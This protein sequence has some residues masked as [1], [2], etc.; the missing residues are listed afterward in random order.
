MGMNRETLEKLNA[1]LGSKEEVVQNYTQPEKGGIAL[2][3]VNNRIHLIFGEEY[4]M[5]V[6]SLENVGTTVELTIPAVTNENGL[7]KKELQ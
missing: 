5:H 6:Y 7:K 3:N 4:G 2:V 1:K